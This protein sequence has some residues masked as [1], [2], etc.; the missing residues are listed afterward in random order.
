MSPCI[1]KMPEEALGR[2]KYITKKEKSVKGLTF[3]NRNNDDDAADT[4]GVMDGETNNDNTID[5]VNP[6]NALEEDNNGERQANHFDVPDDAVLQDDEDENENV[7]DQIHE[8]DSDDDSSFTYRS[9]S[10][11]CKR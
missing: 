3:G 6:P 8:D 1:A 4:I 7:N 9:V 5:H 11:E 2:L 10:C